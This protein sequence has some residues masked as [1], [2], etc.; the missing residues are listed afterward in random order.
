MFPL[1]SLASPLISKAKATPGVVVGHCPVPL[2]GGLAGVAGMIC[3]GRGR[4]AW[5]AC[6]AAAGRPIPRRR[7]L[8]QL[9]VGQEL[10]GKVKAI[11]DS[12]AVVDVGAEYDAILHASKMA[13]GNKSPRDVVEEGMEI[14]V[15]ISGMKS[16]GGGAECQKNTVQGQ[17]VDW[18]KV[19]NQ[20]RP[21]AF[22]KNR[23]LGLLGLMANITKTCSS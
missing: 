6:A 22:P 7:R 13:H 12:H 10:R 9:K 17:L 2:K 3:L 11:M 15:W 8:R 18:M 16:E 21:N 20:N 4:G 1:L 19:T 14:R 5:S 23:F